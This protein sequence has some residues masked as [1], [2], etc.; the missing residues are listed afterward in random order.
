M[1]RS[2]T[3]SK[4]KSKNNNNLNG[5]SCNISTKNSSKKTEIPKNDIAENQTIKK[6]IVLE[7]K[8]EILTEAVFHRKSERRRV[9]RDI[10]LVFEEQPS[11]RRSRRTSKKQVK[12]KFGHL[13]VEEPTKSKGLLRDI[14]NEPK[15]YLGSSNVNVFKAAV[16]GTASVLKSSSNILKVHSG[17]QS[18]TE[19]K[20][21]NVYTN[22]EN[23]DYSKK[24][25]NNIK[26]SKLSGE[27]T[28]SAV[29]AADASNVARV[30]PI[31]LWVKQDDTR[32]V[33]VRCEDYDK[34]NRIR[35]TKT[36]NGWRAIP[37]SDPT[38][39]RVL[40]FYPTPLMKVKRETNAIDANKTL[41]N[42]CKAESKEKHLCCNYTLE[43]SNDKIDNKVNYK[44]NGLNK[45]SNPLV[46]KKSKSK[47][48]KSKKAKKKRDC[49]KPL[50][51][52][53]IN[54]TAVEI[55]NSESLQ[56]SPAKKYSNSILS[57]QTG[58]EDTKIGI[59]YKLNLVEKSDDVEEETVILQNVDVYDREN[60]VIKIVNSSPHSLNSNIIDTMSDTESTYRN[61]SDEKVEFQL[62][63]KTGL[64]LPNNCAN[65]KEYEIKSSVYVDRTSN[66]SLSVEDSFVSSNND[67]A[68]QDI[69]IEHNMDSKLQLI[70]ES[71]DAKTKNLKD[72]LDNADLLQHCDDNANN[73]S[74]LIDSL[75]K[76]TCE[77]NLIQSN[78]VLSKGNLENFQH[79]NL[80]ETNEMVVQIITEVSN[81]PKCLSFNEAG[82]IEGLNGE[83]YQSNVF[84]E[85]FDKQATNTLSDPPI[86]LHSTTTP[87]ETL[88]SPQSVAQR[89]KVSANIEFLNEDNSGALIS[90]ESPKDLSYK[91][92]EEVCPPSESRSQCAVT[93]SSDVI[94][95]PL[96]D[97][98]SVFASSS[99][100]IKNLII[101]QFMK[102]N[103]LTNQQQRDPIDL[104][105]QRHT[106]DVHDKDSYSLKAQQTKNFIETVVIDDDDDGNTEEEQ[107]LKKR[108]RLNGHKVASHTASSNNKGK[109]TLIDKDPD[110]LTQLR[111]LIQNTQWKV[112]DPI[113]VPKDRLSAVLASPAREIPLLITTRPELRLP[114][115]FAYPE[116]IQNPNIL[117][118]SMAQLEAILK[119][120]VAM[121]MFASSQDLEPD[122]GQQTKKKQQSIQTTNPIVGQ[123]SPTSKQHTQQ[124]TNI[125]TGSNLNQIPNNT[126]NASF[127]NSS[128]Q[129]KV[130]DNVKCSQ[131]D[132]S[133]SSDLNAA[134][135]AVLNQM[136]WMPYFGQISQDIIKSIKT[137]LL[138]KENFSNLA[139]LY[140]SDVNNS[141]N[142]ENVY[143]NNTLSGQSISALSS[144][145]TLQG[146]PQT[147]ND[148]TI[149][150]KIVQHQMQNVIQLNQM[151]ADT[152]QQTNSQLTANSG[153]HQQ[154]V[155][156][157]VSFNRDSSKSTQ[158]KNQKLVTSNK[159]ESNLISL[160]K[161]ASNNCNNTLEKSYNL[162]SSVVG[163]Y[164]SDSKQYTNQRQATD[165]KPRLTCKSLSNLLNPQHSVLPTMNS[166]N[167][168]VPNLASDFVKNVNG[169]KKSLVEYRSNNKGSDVK[170]SNPNGMPN[171]VIPSRTCNLTNVGVESTTEFS[172]QKTYIAAESSTEN[173]ENPVLPADTNVPIW[174]PLFGR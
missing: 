13:K 143:K 16:P 99:E 160:C 137:P 128:E 90:E 84:A 15:S 94:K 109:I 28:Q 42:G 165:N 58:L 11:S 170:D 172:K 71:L 80:T 4:S 55:N 154:S 47:N 73:D 21:N 36:S 59:E 82:E 70:E 139:S 32:I 168:F 35:I 150:Q 33:E 89:E 50:N 118:I 161:N 2:T 142:M 44:L 166:L 74:D 88:T 46:T 41:I 163:R 121:G 110:P 1:P 108:L 39:S 12:P 136:L 167:S 9:A 49:E 19:N 40:K 91:K 125:L 151:K 93:S 77:N 164:S 171:V 60:A 6:E 8:T 119:N 54:D 155:N 72:L 130:D 65:N 111:L 85:S 148:L 23:L 67:T 112:P 133:L 62:C 158:Q 169:I 57:L 117:V 141:A 31:F 76:S 53:N 127:E 131:T 29:V 103:V 63:P 134:T 173:N 113:L 66:N 152:V 30:N 157:V 114:E 98:T 124:M 96:H 174:H 5:K 26:S 149:F 86:T 95:S 24:I 100:T 156:N 122:I 68:N 78:E 83:L 92:R 22:R 115:A 144:N 10:F 129:R 48:K 17:R 52:S 18:K 45:V 43:E 107:P 135:V 61:K 64:F 97:N 34:R 20:V 162:R 37:R 106:E 120:E 126:V 69:N 3:K 75:M 87:V 145:T 138:L 146:S 81:P 132:P 102:L 51:K 105:K 14:K 123:Q 153:L 116:I 25:N 159:E 104:G 140:N 79:K 56:M 147:N 101:E 38:T 7:T 27:E